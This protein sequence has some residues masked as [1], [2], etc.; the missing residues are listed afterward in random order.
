[1]ALAQLSLFP[2]AKPFRERFGDA[3]FRRVPAR[4]G[5]YLMSGVSDRLLYVGQSG[6]LRR[7]FNSYKNLSRDN[8]S[9]RLLRLAVAVRQITWEVCA[10]PTEAAVRENEL[11]RLHKP[12]FNVVNTRPEHYVY[13][14]MR[15]DDG[16][17]KLR[18]SDRPVDGTRENWFGA[19]KGMGR[20]R[21]IGKVLERLV[22]CAIHQPRSVFEIPH[23]MMHLRKGTEF[24]LPLGRIKDAPP[25]GPGWLELL[26]EF[27]SGQ[28]DRLIVCLLMRLPRVETISAFQQRFHERELLD[29][30]Q[31]YLHGTRRNLELRRDLGF[32]DGLIGREELDDLLVLRRM[33]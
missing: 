19:F 17:L 2:S 21:H 7:R 26:N 5:V 6:N 27:W 11:L 28:S 16:L 25:G 20:V 13:V 3:F 31:F 33:R 9:R 30:L 29:L 22:W 24:G 32:G 8:A 10:S 23:D 18:V 14:G 15:E 1:M 12:R 4:P